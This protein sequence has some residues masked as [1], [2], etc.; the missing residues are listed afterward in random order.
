MS[1]DP[2]REFIEKNIA[3]RAAADPAFAAYLEAVRNP[4]VEVRDDM[5]L[6]YTPFLL[7]QFTSGVEVTMGEQSIGVKLPDIPG[8]YMMPKSQYDE[9]VA[10]V[11]TGSGDNPHAW[12]PD[13]IRRV[14]EI[15]VASYRGF[16]SEL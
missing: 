6:T 5:T 9:L 16:W 14:A 2:T 7:V 12:S 15:A 8:G 10:P 11:V 13:V 3:V 4:K 1:Q